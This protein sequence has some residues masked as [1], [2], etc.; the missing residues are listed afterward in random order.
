[1]NTFDMGNGATV[2]RIL[3]P[4]LQAD[5]DK[6]NKDKWNVTFVGAHF[7]MTVTVEGAIDEDD[8]ISKAN[9]TVVIHH[10]WIPIEQADQVEAVRL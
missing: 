6:R 3:S 8:A 5:L 4:E 2:S 9:L 10:G 1:M 7:V